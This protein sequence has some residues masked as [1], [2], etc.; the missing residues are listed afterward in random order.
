[1]NGLMMALDL[2]LRRFTSGPVR[3]SASIVENFVQKS[4]LSN[5]RKTKMQCQVC[6]RARATFRE[7]GSNRLLCGKKCQL[8]QGSEDG[9][10]DLLSVEPAQ[11][12]QRLKKSIPD[13]NAASE[14]DF[15][16]QYFAKWPDAPRVW[17]TRGMK[18]IFVEWFDDL[19]DKL[20]W[21]PSSNGNQA[22]IRVAKWG[23]PAVL[24][25]L[26]KDKRVDPHVNND[27]PL[28]NAIK[29]TKSTAVQLLF[30]I[31]VTTKEQFDA[32]IHMAAE[33]GSTGLNIVKVLSN[34][35]RFD[36]EL[37][38]TVFLIT[39]QW[40]DDDM[41]KWL[42]K[43]KSLNVEDAFKNAVMYGRVTIV[44]KMMKKTPPSTEVVESLLEEL[45]DTDWEDEDDTS[46]F[47]IEALME[48]DK[49]DPNNAFMM[50]VNM[51]NINVVKVM[52]K[53]SR[54]RI[55]NIGYNAKMAKR[56]G[57]MDVE[58]FLTNYKKTQKK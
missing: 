55:R 4:Y 44:R 34:D 6:R 25:R 16:R 40:G 21:D 31:C 27:E 58:E 2:G 45:M 3:R 26:L 43:H 49:V 52:L 53:E 57:K 51:G 39:V 37:H 11:L 56:Y 20:G 19:I 15:R 36:T 48:D 32:A 14:F 38:K 30:P 29:A 22:I 17:L 1:M 18:P 50:A 13:R 24:K 33:R 54:G 12:P 10:L 5:E 8:I 35:E 47:I 9:D 7:A 23:T 46:L 28:R 42:L 41:A